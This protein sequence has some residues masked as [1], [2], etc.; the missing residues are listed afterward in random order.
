MRYSLKHA[1]LVIFLSSLLPD[2]FLAQQTPA[3]PPSK[4][5][6]AAQPDAGA[7]SDNVYTNDFFGFSYT[8]PANWR[9]QSKQEQREIVEEGH[10][11]VRG[12]DPEE[13]EEHQ[14]AM[15]WMWTLFGAVKDLKAGALGPSIQIVAFDLKGD[16]TFKNPME[17]LSG[18]SEEM[19][20]KGAKVVQ[21]PA[22]S[23]IAG[24]NFFTLKMK[25][26]I[27]GS[28]PQTV[29]YA[30]TITIERGYALT[31]FLFADSPAALQE[32][33]D[34]LNQLKFRNSAN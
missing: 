23:S 2:A 31:W 10:K 6:A 9:A 26:N 27:P 30:A 25:F 11:N 15:K 12:N 28:S 32:L 16:P 1:S 19:K 8:F 24:R 29:H 17:F 20:E 13:S 21:K 34:G 5:S 7:V 22:E 14:E 33:L 4:I 18:V 3:P